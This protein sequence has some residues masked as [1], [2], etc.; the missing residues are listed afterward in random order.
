MNFNWDISV[1]AIVLS[2]VSLGA[3]LFIAGWTI[4]RDAIARPKFKVSFEVVAAY[5]FGRE[6]YHVQIKATN[7]GRYENRA[8]KVMLTRSK[9]G[10]EIATWK[11]DAVLHNKNIGEPVQPGDSVIFTGEYNKNCILKQP[12][13]KYVAVV[14][15]FDNWYYAS[16]SQVNEAN[17]RYRNDFPPNIDWGATRGDKSP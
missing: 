6:T 13:W 9:K 15:P 4:Y 2:L 5:G 11:S 16:R 12:S 8:N 10:A 1:I 14:D 3:S 17:Q 7:I